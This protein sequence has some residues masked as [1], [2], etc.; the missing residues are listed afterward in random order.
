MKSARLTALRR[1]VRRFGPLRTMLMIVAL[2]TAYSVALTWVVGPW[3]I[4]PIGP[5]ALL[6][7]AVIPMLVAPP[8]LIICINLLHDLDQAEMR[9]RELAVVDD[10][11]G[12]YSRR[13]V[14]EAA[15]QIV[16]R[17][18]RYG[19]GLAT[20][21]LDI[22]QFKQVNDTHGH[23][24]GDQVLKH[25]KRT[26][27]SHL[28][29]SDILVRYGGEEFLVILPQTGAATAALI[30]ERLRTAIAS[31]VLRIGD[32]DLPVTASFGVASVAPGDRDLEPL[33]GRADQMLYAA[34]RAGRNRVISSESG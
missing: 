25:I 12:A 14:T 15:E 34:K 28:R 31:R 13:F 30:A 33:I 27:D 5:G 9:L 10:L 19:E 18:V 24:V 32:L 21:M 4:G 23:M 20:I 7:G 2:S 1:M 11:T 6:L 17:A 22:D 16:S 3:F 29:T 26:C 8:V